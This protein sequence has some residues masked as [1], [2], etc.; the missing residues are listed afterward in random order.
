M[1]YFYT[2]TKLSLR[3]KQWQNVFIVVVMALVFLEQNVI[4]APLFG[5]KMVTAQAVIIENNL[6][7]L[8]AQH[9]KAAEKEK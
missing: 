5:V 8:M 2:V 9:V 6:A 7:D 3:Y 1:C 4:H